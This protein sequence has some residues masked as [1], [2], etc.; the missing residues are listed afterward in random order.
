MKQKSFHLFA[1]LSLLS[2]SSFSFGMERRQA[3]MHGRPAYIM[4]RYSSD[5]EL[6]KP[7]N[8]PLNKKYELD[9]KLYTYR[10]E[11][12]YA[13]G[14]QT[15]SLHKF[16]KIDDDQ[17]L[18]D[19]QSDG[20]FLITYAVTDRSNSKWI[21]IGQGSNCNNSSSTWS[22]NC[23]DGDEGEGFEGNE[24]SLCTFLLE[25]Y[26]Q[27]DERHPW[28]ARGGVVVATL[29]TLWVLKKTYCWCFGSKK[30]A[31]KKAPLSNRR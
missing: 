7:S 2:I 16:Y 9:G 29:G 14:R 1:L 24:P 11:G 12:N 30:A 27:Y 28:K 15:V 10:G 21:S 13:I 26:K 31:S 6:F 4:N 18:L 23:N 3:A 20:S 8:L 17:L 5:N 19:N 25:R 22:E